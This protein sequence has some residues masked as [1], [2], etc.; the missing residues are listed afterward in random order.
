MRKRVLGLVLMSGL[1]LAGCSNEAAKLQEEID[2]VSAAKEELVVSLN[3][4][5]TKET[6]LQGNF[7]ESLEADEELKN[8]ADKTASVY[9]NMESRKETL[10]TI[11][12]TLET[13][14]EDYE[15]L[16]AFD[17]ESLPMDQVAALTDTIKE[18]DTAVK[19]Y[20]PAYEEQLSKEEEVYQSIGSEEADFNILFDGVSTLNELSDENVERL[21][22]LLEWFEK[23]DTQASE[24][25][26]ELAAMEEK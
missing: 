1:F 16:S 21:R 26:A 11:S 14:Q 13:I 17:E 25:S 15:D 3:D 20:V 2:S 6:E 9:T 22:P 8:F 18:M 23:F 7:N 12:E 24:L 5:Q 19:A 4:I 10:A